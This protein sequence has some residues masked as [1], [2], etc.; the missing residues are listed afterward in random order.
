MIIDGKKIARGTLEGLR[1]Q[2]GTW[3]EKIFA[4]F[5]VGENKES[6]S[7]LKQ[8]EKFAKELG[9]EFRLYRLSEDPSNDALRKK[10][11]IIIRGSRFGGGI[12]QLP[13]PEK[14]SEQVILNAI[15]KE[16][17][18]DCLT[19]QA[20]GG[21]YAGRWPVMPPAVAALKRILGEIHCTLDDKNVVVVGRGR[22]IG[23]PI[24]L[25]L[26]DKT[27]EFA[28]LYLENER[29]FQRLKDADLIISGVGKP[30]I[31]KGPHIKDGA[32][33]V[34]FGYYF[35]QEKI[36]GDADFESCSQK[37]SYIT[38]TPGGTGPIVVAE[39]FYNFY[40]LNRR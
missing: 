3:R 23:K 14:Y 4:A 32:A 31:I 39:L 17:D 34:D 38:P 5:L 15:P 27:R 9:I 18:V 37:A 25:W 16:K 28:S 33:I 11:G 29:S 13:L 24:Y 2:K 12:I 35:D 40:L 7:F 1:A 30:H 22:L 26:L 19:E 10:I 21:F 8:K 36:L 6:E 20:L